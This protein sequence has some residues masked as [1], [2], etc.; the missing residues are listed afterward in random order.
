MTKPL[1][2][3]VG[4]KAYC[5]VCEETVTITSIEPDLYGNGDDGY[6]HA[7]D[8]LRQV[9]APRRCYRKLPDRKEG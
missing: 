4:K 8:V 6:F 7:G 1:P 9:S 2:L 5:K 3:T